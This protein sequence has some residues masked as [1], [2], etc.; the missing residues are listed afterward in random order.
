MGKLL[1]IPK[2][3][4]QIGEE[5]LEVVGQGPEGGIDES[6]LLRG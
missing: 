1:Y 3:I 6:L 5:I 2:I 4:F